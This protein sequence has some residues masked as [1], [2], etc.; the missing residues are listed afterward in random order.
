MNKNE[1]NYALPKK[2]MS[3]MAIGFVIIV[4]GVL[5]MAGGG[6]D[7]GSFNPAIFSFQRITLAPMVVLFGFVFEIVAILWIPKSQKQDKE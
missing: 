2:N 7:D 6:S 5:L 1:V 3:L 4:I